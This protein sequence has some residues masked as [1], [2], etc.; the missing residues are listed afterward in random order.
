M[1]LILFVDLVNF[2][3]I[4]SSVE[5]GQIPIQYMS[6]NDDF[7]VNQASESMLA[8]LYDCIKC[9]LSMYVC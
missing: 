8:M 7:F 3:R 9:M 1:L 4:L 2:I 5:L 6:G